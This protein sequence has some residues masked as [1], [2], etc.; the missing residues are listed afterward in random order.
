MIE[1]IS[2]VLLITFHYIIIFELRQISKNGDEYGN[3]TS[4]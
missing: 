1:Y 2:V 3:Y 4:R